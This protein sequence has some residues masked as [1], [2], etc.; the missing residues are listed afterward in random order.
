MSLT[1]LM[2]GMKLSLYPQIA[3]VIFLCVFFAVAMR[4]YLMPRGDA[5]ELARMPIDDTDRRNRT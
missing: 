4:V 5:D 3:L 1:D 2:S